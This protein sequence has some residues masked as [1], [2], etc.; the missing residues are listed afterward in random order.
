MANLEKSS[1]MQLTIKD[2]CNKKG[3]SA[4]QV[5]GK[6]SITEDGNFLSFSDQAAIVSHYLQLKN[7]PEGVLYKKNAEQILNEWSSW[8][9]EDMTDAVAHGDMVSEPPVFQLNLFHD[10]LNAP[11]H[12]S[13]SPKFTFVDLFAGIGGIRIPFTELGGKCVFSS[14]WDKAAQI[15]YSYN[16][17][18]VPFGDITKINSDSIPKHDVLLAGFPCQA[19]SIIGKMKGFADTRGTMFF[20]VARI[21]QHHQPKAILLENVKQLVSHDGGKTFKVILD[22]LAELGYSVKWKILNALDFGLPQ[23]RERVI[24]VGF[25]S[26]AACEQF[27]FDFEPIAYNLASV[28]EDDKNVDSSLF[29]S[30]MILDKR[31]KRVEGKNVFYPSVWH[32]NKSGNISIL[33]Y[34]CALRT[35]ASYNYLLINGYRRPSSRE[36]LRFQGFPEKFKIEVSHQEIRRQTGNSVAVPMI[37]AV[38]KKII[39]LL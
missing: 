13:A 3:I 8:M 9:D 35:G 5:Y 16:F 29:A 1:R 2:F 6:S 23:K 38:A 21:L 4:V 39:Q 11:F 27:N 30:D 31:R 14:E 26:A 33:P 17:G 28:L 22:T 10:L 24:I 20:E 19:F 18:E 7:R 34:A 15:S 25:K 37:R 32:E 36:L 12:D